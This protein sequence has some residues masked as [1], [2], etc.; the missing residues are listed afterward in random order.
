[1]NVEVAVAREVDHPLGNDPSVS[2]NDDSVGIDCCELCLQLR[3]V[4]DALGLCD[5]EIPRQGAL[6]YGR[7]TEFHSASTRLVWLREYQ[8]Q[9][10][11]GV[12]ESLEGWNRESWSAGEDE[13]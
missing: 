13:V 12:D 11:S 9:L 10:M 1:M 7:S 5:C 4:L 2:H 8:R 6:L 3:I